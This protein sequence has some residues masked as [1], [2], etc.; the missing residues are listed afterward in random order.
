MIMIF[1]IVELIPK[2]DRRSE[3]GASGCY[4][5]CGYLL[6]CWWV[7]TR[8]SSLMGNLTSQLPT[9]FWILKSR[10]LAGKPSFCTTRA[11]FLAAS[12]DCS[13]LAPEEGGRE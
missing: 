10:N 8:P 5:T 9:M 6:N 11:Y 12:L 13:S 3:P 7:R 1:S 4:G 2:A